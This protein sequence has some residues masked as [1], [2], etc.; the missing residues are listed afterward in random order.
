[1]FST[2]YYF[3]L[4]ASSDNFAMHAT[5]SRCFNISNIF[6]KSTEEFVNNVL[7][8]ISIKFRVIRNYG[9]LW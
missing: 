5:L 1:M 2:E 6:E 3:Y 4:T 8:S 7:Q 9:D